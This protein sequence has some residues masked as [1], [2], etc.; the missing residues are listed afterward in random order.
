MQIGKYN[1]DQILKASI[2][3][4]EKVKF[5]FLG[6]FIAA[7]VYFIF[8]GLAIGFA[9]QK[10]VQTIILSL[11]DFIASLVVLLTIIG[12]TFTYKDAFS[13]KKKMLPTKKLI[14]MSMQKMPQLL[15]MIILYILVAE[16]GILFSG[17][18]P[19]WGS[20]ILGLL[21]LPLVLFNVIFLI[22]V[23]FG[24]KLLPAFLVTEKIKIIDGFKRLNQLVLNKP[25][26]L[27][28]Y[29]SLILLVA[30][31]LVLITCTLFGLG[32]YITV[33]IQQFAFQKVLLA[34]GMIEWPSLVF[35]LFTGVSYLAL[36]ALAIS[37]I[38]VL[39]TAAVY[40]VYLAL[41]TK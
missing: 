19:V 4:K 37:F 21:T 3:D 36:G 11:G 10:L 22:L 24:L 31:P 12:L 35:G 2:F 33:F 18:V 9:P 15:G 28:V 13:G 8:Q 5:G 29:F 6:L 32:S 39:T 30:F 23:T 27:V 20:L 16:I 40:S 25:V 7:I 34:G 41:K 38:T 14:S 1:L 17:K 26:Q